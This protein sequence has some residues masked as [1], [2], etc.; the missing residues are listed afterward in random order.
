[1]NQITD[2]KPSDFSTDELY[3]KIET[4]HRLKSGMHEVLD[5]INKDLRAIEIYL[6]CFDL[7]NSYMIACGA[8]TISWDDKF[9]RLSVQND[10]LTYNILAAPIHC[11]VK[12]HAN[13]GML[14]DKIISSWED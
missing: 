6:E 11:R 14:L 9:K 1:M 2:I 5:K 12:A 7:P 3:I 10:G 4:I 8:M 13:M